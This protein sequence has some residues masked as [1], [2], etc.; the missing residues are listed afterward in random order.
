MYFKNEAPIDIVEHFL[1]Y[2][3]D[4]SNDLELA[5]L[6]NMTAY[7]FFKTFGDSIWIIPV[8]VYCAHRDMLGMEHLV[9]KLENEEIE[10]VYK[11]PGEQ[12]IANWRTE[13]LRIGDLYMTYLA[14][15]YPFGK[16]EATG[17]SRHDQM[18]ISYF[19]RPSVAIKR[20]GMFTECIQLSGLLCEEFVRNLLET[21]DATQ[22]ESK[23][24]PKFHYEFFY[25]ARTPMSIVD[26]YIRW[27]LN[28]HRNSDLALSKREVEDIV[29]IYGKDEWVVPECINHNANLL[30]G[31][32]DMQANVV[33]E[34]DV[35]KSE[36]ELCS[37]QK[38]RCEELLGCIKLKYSL[39]QA[40]FSELAATPIEACPSTVL[41]MHNALK[42]SDVLPQDKW[43]KYIRLEKLPLPGLREQFRI[44]KGFEF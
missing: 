44:T 41:V 27:P 11:N 29:R 2:P 43:M 26:E 9:H 24:A 14:K 28:C 20:F 32:A 22:L 25:Q 36:G 12:A 33:C 19:E 17:L 3:Y 7:E 38:V 23:D 15:K 42:V 5:F 10:S 37:S 6:E 39:L 1:D 4:D 40:K 8:D 30:R 34:L 13:I 16:V 18:L 31:L 21:K 35:L